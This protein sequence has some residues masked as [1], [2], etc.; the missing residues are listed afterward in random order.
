MAVLTAA[1]WAEIAGAFNKM[2]KK[3]HKEVEQKLAKSRKKVEAE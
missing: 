3:T 1:S 2:K